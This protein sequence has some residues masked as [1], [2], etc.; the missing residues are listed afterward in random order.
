MAIT[1]QEIIASDTI[2]QLVD[3]TNF[4]F[5][6]IL[7]NGGGPEGPA[8]IQGPVGPAGGRGPKGTRWYEDSSTSAPGA[9]PLAV[10]PTTTPLE[11]DYYL[12]F[13]GMVWEYNGTTWVITTIDLEGPMGPQGPGGGFGDTFGSPTI[14]LQ[15]AIYNGPIGLG[16]GATTGNEGVPS[17]MIGG[18]VSTTISLA[19]LPLTNAYVI[20]DTVADKLISSTASLLI[21]QKDSTAKSIVFHGGAANPSDNYHQANLAALSNINIGIDDKLVLSVPKIPTNPTSLQELIGLEIQT[22]YRSQNF[23]AGKAITLS[24]GSDTVSRYGSENSDFVINVGNGSAPGGNEFRVATGG[25]AGASLFQMGTGFPVN[26]S[27]NAQV[28]V[29]QIQAG[30]IQ[31]TS[32]VNQNI[33]L[34]SG[35]QLK[36]DSRNGTNPAGAIQMR[37]GTGGVFVDVNAGGNINIEQTDSSATAEGDIF[38]TNN[39]TAPNTVVGGDIYITGN[40]Q[41]ILRKET[42]TALNACSIVIDYGYDGSAGAQPHTRF[43]GRQTVAAEGLSSSDGHPVASFQNLIFKNPKSQMAS[44]SAIYEL[45]GTNDNSDYTP[46]AM[47]QGWTG[48]EQATSGVSAGLLGIVLGSEGPTSPVTAGYEAFDNSLG[49]G[50]MNENNTQDYFMASRNKIAFAAPW[51]LKRSNLKN[52]TINS[53]PTNTASTLSTMSAPMNFGWNTEQDLGFG[54]AQD[55]SAGLPTTADLNLPYVSINYGPG[56][57]YTDPAATFVDSNAGYSYK[58]NFPLGQYPGQRLLVKFY[59]Q[60]VAYGDVDKFGNPINITNYGQVNLRI[61]SRRTKVPK[62]TGNWTGWWDSVNG[63]T[64]LS[65]GYQTSALVTDATDAG[66]GL[67]KIKMIDMVWDGQLVTMTGKEADMTSPN[68]STNQLQMG[69]LIVNQSTAKSLFY[70]ATHISGDNNDPSCFVAGTMISLANGDYKNIEDVQAGEEVMSYNESTG[71]HETAT[72]GDIKVREV[73]SIIRLVFANGNIIKTTEEHPFYV[74]G[75]WV[76]AN[77]LRITDVAKSLDGSEVAITGIEHIT[78]PHTV[79]NLLDVSGNSNF[80]AGEILVHNKVSD[81]RLKENYQQIG[82]SPSGIPIY[83]FSY[84]G[85]PGRYIG[86]MAQDLIK[87]GR[88]DAIINL[89]MD[90]YGVDYSKIDVDCKDLTEVETINL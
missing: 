22:D 1:I 48:G 90:Y 60:S 15:T 83:K 21:H 10:P 55:V 11:G 36:L 5:D 29:A 4:N 45:T 2:S 32:S 54:T 74:N 66:N 40:S 84:K 12:Q 81:I 61:P 77:E 51:V 75:E 73:D 39:S 88:T 24:T 57:G 43:V 19:G 89:D 46:G 52:S 76:K 3:K 78:E 9:T 72:V 31:L 28:G 33:Q 34:F 23:T 35:G 41:L 30:L 47:L 18:A 85:K 49:F 65:A 71:E 20:P 79:Y 63:T 8:G 44:S 25:T 87:L 62:A 38:I 37:S 7:L 86:T 16:N 70:T 69:W 53:A 26:L 42:S 27:Q 64:N 56:L 17:V 68:A 67:G 13:N 58:A 6:Q 59:L 14:G 82:T 50:V 80:Y